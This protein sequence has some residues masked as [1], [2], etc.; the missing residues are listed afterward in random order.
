MSIILKALAKAQKKYTD[1]AK[2]V[3]TKSKGGNPANDN[4][5]SAPQQQTVT[6]GDSP[7]NFSPSFSNILFVVGIAALIGLTVL[8]NNRVTSR[9][10]VT[11]GQMADMLGHLKD[12]EE[13]IVELNDA[14]HKLEATSNS[15]AK[16][17]NAG[18]EKMGSDI[19]TR[20]GNLKG[21][22][23]NQKSVWDNAIQEHGQAIS[24]TRELLNS[25]ETENK[26]LKNQIETLKEKVDAFTSIPTP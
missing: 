9:I 23:N 13:K 8:Y 2:A 15:Q 20:I 5:D 3:L 22:L 26:D 17:T 7:R 25:Y 6:A 1:N 14:L 21:E 12:Q 10:N 11:N 4:A 18:F 24:K 19:Q 16:D